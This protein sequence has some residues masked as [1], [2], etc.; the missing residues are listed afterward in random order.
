MRR[1]KLVVSAL[2]LSSLLSSSPLLAQRTKQLVVQV[3]GANVFVSEG[4]LLD[5]G[6]SAG[7]LLGLRTLPQTWLMGSFAYGWHEGE[8]GL[9]D[10][11]TQSYFAMLGYDIVPAGMNG[12]WIFYVG[13]GGIAFDPEA[14][15][16]ERRTYFAMNGGMKLIFDVSRHVAWTLDLG[17]AVAFSEEAYS[18]GEVWFWPLGI[19]LAY[20]LP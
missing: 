10:W 1:H 8:D 12:N 2:V 6:L 18:G 7:A 14:A 13:A 3:Y 17:F 20:H 5:R 16:A 9:P 4:V 19:G 11:D 15:D